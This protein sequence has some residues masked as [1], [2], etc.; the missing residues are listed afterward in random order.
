MNRSTLAAS[1]I[2]GL[3]LSFTV[4]VLAAQQ[5]DPATARKPSTDTNAASKIEASKECLRD[6]RVFHS[7]MQ[8]DGY[9]L[10]GSGYG[11]GYPIYGYGYDYDYDLG[12]TSASETT[13]YGR[14]RPGFEIRTL[15]A[16]ADILARRGGQQQ[17]CKALLTATRD[18]YTGYVA[19]MRESG[20][21]QADMRG[22]RHQQIA[23]AQPVTSNNASYRSDQLIGT[24]VVN[25][26]GEAL[27]SVDDIIHRPQTGKI[28]YLVVG[29]GGVFG[30]GE[31][32]VPVPWEVFKA[33]TN[34]LVL[35][36]TKS[37]MDAAP[38]VQEDQFS[39]NGNF[40]QQSAKVEDYW[41]SNLSK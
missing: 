41:K 38:Q 4:P 8:E 13:D 10:G 40:D 19:D 29:R 1:L 6:L 16:S 24:D 28:A 32:Y 39:P 22:W 9:W 17:A 33:S 37:G 18:I 36:T 31:N 5:S 11:Y 30:I 2:A 35:D 12:G 21:T 34:L 14:G 26:E 27:G 7:Q 23:T 25:L 3:Y 15:I 20:M